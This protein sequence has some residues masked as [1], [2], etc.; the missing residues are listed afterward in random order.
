MAKKI[1]ISLSEWVYDRM[2]GDERINKSKR[3]EELMIKG[4]FSPLNENSEP[5]ANTPLWYNLNPLIPQPQ[6]CI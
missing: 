1:T 6:I 3:I 2:V 5:S 4:F